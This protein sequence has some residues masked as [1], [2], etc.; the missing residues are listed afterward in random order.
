MVY[1]VHGV[2]F[3]VFLRVLLFSAARLGEALQM[4]WEGVGLPRRRLVIAGRTTK[5]GRDSYIP[6][7]RPLVAALRD[8]PRPR[9]GRLFPWS[10]GSHHVQKTWRGIVAESGVPYLK[11]HCLRHT[12]ATMLVDAGLR[13]HQLSQILHASMATTLQYYVGTD[14]E[15]M[16]DAGREIARSRYT[17]AI[18]R[19]STKS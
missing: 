17:T 13:P 4:A 10:G 16:A 8:L 11:L 9:R 3:D 6:L 2:R 12:A 19:K 18:Q 15:I 14:R 5:T 1:P 7:S